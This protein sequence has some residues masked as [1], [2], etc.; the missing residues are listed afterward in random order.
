[1]DRKHMSCSLGSRMYMVEGIGY[2]GDWGIE[3][4]DFRVYND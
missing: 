3:Y 1:M 2:I 4:I